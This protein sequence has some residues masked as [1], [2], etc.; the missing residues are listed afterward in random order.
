MPSKSNP[1]SFDCYANAE[2][3]EPMFVLLGRD[4]LAPILVEM[5]ATLRDANNPRPNPAKLAE[6]RRCAELM[7]TWREQRES[8]GPA[9]GS[10]ATDKPRRR[11]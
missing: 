3:D 1:D 7:R 11:L 5:W 10:Q 4:P 2:P 9:T 8:S 6:A